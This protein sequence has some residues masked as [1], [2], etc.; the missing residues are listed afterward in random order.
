MGALE[1]MKGS[2]HKR[3]TKVGRFSNHL[4][5]KIISWIENKLIANVNPLPLISTDY[6]PYITISL[7]SYPGRINQ[8]AFAIKSIMLQTMRP[9]RVML[10]LAEEQFPEHKLPEQLE[11]LKK[12]GLEIRF[13]PDDLRSHKKYFYALKSQKPGEVVITIDDDIIYHP[14]TIERAMTM[15]QLFPNAVVCNSAHVVTFD[16][17]NNPLPY[18]SWGGVKDYGDYSNEILTPLTGSGCLYPYGIMPPT[19]FDVDLIKKTS[20]T[21]DDLW[22]AAMININ[23]IELRTTDV[24]ART[25]TTVADSQTTHL[26][27]LNCIENG[28]DIVINKLIKKFPQFLSKK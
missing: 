4:R 19:T 7:T 14:L 20:F 24:V 18:S 27:Q 23:D 16:E 22:I 1:R 11:D 25:F 17:F 3:K 5:Y 21:A 8:V 2:T 13:C 12:V 9:N 26:G 15:H 10:W 6:E 28:N